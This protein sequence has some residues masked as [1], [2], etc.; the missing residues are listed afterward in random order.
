MGRTCARRIRETA[1]AAVE[2]VK[3]DTL[4]KA[5]E[6]IEDGAIVDTRR[7]TSTGHHVYA[8]V[9]SDGNDTYLTTT[10]A[11]VCRAGVAGRVCRHRVAAL[12]LTA[13]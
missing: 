9:S 6:D 8:V 3:P 12:I 4:A 13:A 1:A 7:T 11:C 5:V 2:L 10:H